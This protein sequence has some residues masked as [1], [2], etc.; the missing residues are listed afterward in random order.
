[1]SNLRKQKSNKSLKLIT[2]FWRGLPTW[3]SRGN[4]LRSIIHLWGKWSCWSNNKTISIMMTTLTTA[5]NNSFTALVYIPCNHGESLG[6]RNSSCRSN[7]YEPEIVCFFP[8]SI[9]CLSCCL[10]LRTPW[11]VKGNKSLDLV[12][13]KWG[14]QWWGTLKHFPQSR[15]I[16]ISHWSREE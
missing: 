6:I 14:S 10:L 4:F 12:W 1:M 9:C 3:E 8:L 2:I 11:S 16:L 13:F 7:P 15:C 5:V